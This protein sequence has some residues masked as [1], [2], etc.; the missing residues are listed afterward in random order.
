MFTN[1]NVNSINY[2]NGSVTVTATNN[3]NGQTLV[4]EGD[5]IVCTASIGVLRSGNLQ[6]SP[7]LPKWKT[8]AINQ[9]EM[10]NYVKVFCTFTQK[11]WRK[12]ENIFIASQRKGAFP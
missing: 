12:H 6:F 2:E 3:S 1:F 11:F 4:F 7:P 5:A 8:D 10:G 9:V